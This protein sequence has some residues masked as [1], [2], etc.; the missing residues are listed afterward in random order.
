MGNVSSYDK[1]IQGMHNDVDSL[2]NRINEEANRIINLILENKYNDRDTVCSKLGYQKVDE[3][4]NSF[5]VTTLEGISHRLGTISSTDDY[6][7][8]KKHPSIENSNLKHSSLETHKKQVC[9]DIVN[10][11]I[12]KINLI[13]SIQRELPKCKDMEEKVYNNLKSELDS[14]NINE[15]EWLNIYNRLEK[16]NKDIKTRYQLIE[17]ELDKIRSAKKM[18]DLDIISNNVNN[19]L[20]KTNSICQ[21]QAS[22]FP[23]YSSPSSSR[24]TQVSSS[25]RVTQVSSPSR[26]T[27]VSS[28]SRVTQVSSPSRVTVSQTISPPPQKVVERVRVNQVTSPQVSSTPRVH[29]VVQNVPVVQ[30]TIVNPTVVR[31]EIIENPVS[32]VVNVP[33]ST[34]SF[35]TSNPNTI[36]KRIPPESFPEKSSSTLVR[37]KADKISRTPV[38]LSIQN[39]SRIE[40]SRVIPREHAIAIHRSLKPGTKVVKIEPI[41]NTK[42]KA[43]P[44][45]AISSHAP[46]TSSEI[47]LRE[48]QPTLYLGRTSNGWAKVRHADSRE[49]YVPYSHLSL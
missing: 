15:E 29:T 43:I 9:L 5:N 27:Q 49:G 28:P 10:F 36:P 41:Y 6:G 13:T 19:I 11:Y 42:E 12:N 16:F 46:L 31:H 35:T 37:V 21:S 14:K 17:V 44:V 25:S 33:N 7:K 23:S 30:R 32:N 26:V 24:V 45:K 48:G 38:G 8:Q 34:S 40:T 47:E 1:N 18:R 3:L 22:S 20:K 39:P 2:F 4:S